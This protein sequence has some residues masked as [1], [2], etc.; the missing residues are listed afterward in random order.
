MIFIDRFV[1]LLGARRL[2]EQQVGIGYLLLEVIPAM[3][4]GF[5]CGAMAYEGYYLIKFMR[6]VGATDIQISL[7]PLL[8]FSAFAL[9]YFFLRSSDAQQSQNS[10]ALCIKECI[11]GRGI[12]LLIPLWPAIVHLCGWSHQLSIY[13]ILLFFFCAHIR[14]F[15]GLTYF[16]TWTQSVISNTDRGFFLAWRSISVSLTLILCISVVNYLWPQNISEEGIFWWYIGL[17]T[18]I[19]ICCL[20]ST[21]L[22]HWSPDM[23]DREEVHLS[24]TLSTSTVLQQHP[25]L[26]SIIYW[27]ALNGAASCFLLTWLPEHMD[28]L[29]IDEKIIS[30][31]QYMSE[32][33][34]KIVGFIAAVFLLHRIGGI[35]TLCIGL[36]LWPV[37]IVMYLNMH[38][39][40]LW[41]LLP[42][43]MGLFGLSRAVSQIAGITS[44]QNLA[45][46][47]DI[48][49]PA[50]NFF[51]VGIGGL[52]A[53]LLMIASV[54]TLRNANIDGSWPWTISETM[55]AAAGI[56]QT[57]GIGILL[58]GIF[59]ER[60]A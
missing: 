44:L 15:I 8:Y 5:I 46:R 42:I 22:L 47:H 45:P 26:K 56:C 13:G 12:W 41:Y 28:N 57:I 35:Y 60:R 30:Q 27:S 43:C 59:Q 18:I 49:I 25:Q 29:H 11:Y 23:Q 54:H 50:L 36:S 14:M 4:W 9:Q 48:R 3:V 34:M 51:A 39:D 38:S 21:L 58:R 17:F 2:A 40:N 19:T 1:S 52:C 10:K 7:L 31:W 32:I 55:F 53:S 33:P 37:L 20:L 24:S 16:I 6:L